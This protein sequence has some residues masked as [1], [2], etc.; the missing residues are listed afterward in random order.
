MFLITLWPFNSNFHSHWFPD[1]MFPIVWKQLQLM[2]FFASMEYLGYH[3]FF[4]QY[5]S[6]TSGFRAFF[7]LTQCMFKK[8]PHNP[9]HTFLYNC[10]AH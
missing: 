2:G 3:K 6:Y 5:I 10:L 9:V 8:L 7:F 4:C 1:G